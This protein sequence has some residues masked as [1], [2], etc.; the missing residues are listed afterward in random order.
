MAYTL[1]PE[2]YFCISHNQTT[3]LDIKADRYFGLPADLD[4]AFQGWTYHGLADL[5]DPSFNRLVAMNLLISVPHVPDIII[6]T[7]PPAKRS[8][9][10]HVINGTDG[11][12][13]SMSAVLHQRLAAWELRHRSL[14]SIID[15]L[16]RRKLKAT[17]CRRSC[18]CDSAS[19]V[20]AF[21]CT[22][23]VIAN[24]DQCLRRSI[25]LVDY[26][27]GQRLFPLFVIG[28][29]RQPFGA[30]AWVQDEDEVLNDHVDHVAEYVPILAV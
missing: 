9:L 22:G 27:A 12:H 1:R 11:P 14:S 23:R 5:A 17:E 30:H 2:L 28:V 13:F 26:L 20:K 19:I 4:A 18:F 21:L 15:R 8:A 24:Q 10:E 29:R 25:A 16:R 3:F 7:L 6:P